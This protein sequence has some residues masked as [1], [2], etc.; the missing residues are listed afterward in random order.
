MSE[1]VIEIK[2]SISERVG[3]VLGTLKSNHLV[4]A[5]IG[6]VAMEAV[7]PALEPKFLVPTFFLQFIT[8]VVRPLYNDFLRNQTAVLRARETGEPRK[9][10][11]ERHLI[12]IFVDAWMSGRPQLSQDGWY[13]PP[14]YIVE[15]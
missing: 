8:T 7:I 11:D 15:E 3:A 5:E 14:G 9:L 2:P 12:Q 6:L 10:K 13:Y 1:E 4:Q